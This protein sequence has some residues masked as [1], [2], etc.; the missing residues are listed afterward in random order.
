ML[1][2]PNSKVSSLQAEGVEIAAGDLLDAE[3]VYAAV[4]GCRVVYHA[5]GL[6]AA[7]LRDPRLIF[8]SHIVGT[9]NVLESA[10]KTGVERVVYTSSAITIGERR[11]EVGNEETRHRGTYHS[12]MKRLNAG[13]NRWRGSTPGL[14]CRWSS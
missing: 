5:G 9:R 2:R 1:A 8:Q 3:F 14:G 10:Q 11:G 4:R 6:Y 13:Q 7:G 12:N